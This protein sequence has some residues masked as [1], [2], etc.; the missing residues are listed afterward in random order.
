MELFDISWALD[1]FNKQDRN[2]F[3]LNVFCRCFLLRFV[4]ESQPSWF[5]KGRKLLPQT[6]ALGGR[7][8]TLESGISSAFQN[9]VVGPEYSGDMP[10]PTWRSAVDLSVNLG[11]S[12]ALTLYPLPQHLLL[13]LDT[14]DSW[15]DS[16]QDRRCGRHVRVQC[17]V[18]GR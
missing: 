8:E 13:W 7:L 1:V 4:K 12:E 15:A 6:W 2:S 5:S 18:S 11:L 3:K 10:Q 17:S 16:S 14:R 9:E